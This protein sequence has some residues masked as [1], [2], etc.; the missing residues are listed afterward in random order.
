MDD[1]NKH[2]DKANGHDL[3]R[4]KSDKLDEKTNWFRDRM[5]CIYAR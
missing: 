2:Y 1:K 4:I 3:P 5:M